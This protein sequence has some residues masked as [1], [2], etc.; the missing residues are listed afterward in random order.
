MS[1]P[2]FDF[3]QEVAIVRWPCCKVGAL[4]QKGTRS[5]GMDAD[6]GA[7]LSALKPRPRASGEFGSPSSPR[8]NFKRVSHSQRGLLI[9]LQRNFLNKHYV[10]CN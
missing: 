4:V 1:D 3:D 10:A 9:R 2:Q 7:D 6:A 5:N 8:L